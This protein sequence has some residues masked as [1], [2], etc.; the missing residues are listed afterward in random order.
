M[1]L[2]PKLPGANLATLHSLNPAVGGKLQEEYPP[3]VWEFADGD[4][5]GGGII[6][7]TLA[8]VGLEIFGSPGTVGVAAS[9]LL[10]PGANTKLEWVTVQRTGNSESSANWE[11][12]CL[13]GNAAGSKVDSG[14]LYASYLP[15]NRKLSMR[16]P[17]ACDLFR[18][19]LRISGGVGRTPAD[20]VVGNFALR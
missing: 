9:K 13:L 19:D 16:V 18:V 3:F 7:L 2:Y 6:G 20:L 17:G 11:M 15:V 10:V 5:Q 12:T 1:R 4:A 8:N 14:N